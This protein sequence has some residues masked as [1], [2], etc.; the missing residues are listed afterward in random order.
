MASLRRLSLFLTGAYFLTSFLLA[1]QAL[2]AP[3]VLFQSITVPDSAATYPLSINK[4]LIITGYY[5][6]NSGK[7]HGFVRCLDGR[8]TTFDVPG[9]VL[10]KPVSINAAGEI[11][12]YYEIAEG[13]VPGTLG[14]IRERDGA[15]T[16]FGTTAYPSS[17]PAQPVAINNAGEVVGNFP[18]AGL[19]SEA[20]VR[21]STGIVQTFSIT[22]GAAYSTFLTAVNAH[23]AV[24]G[25]GGS[26][27]LASAHGLLWNGQPPAPSPVA[28]FTE[29][30][31]PGSTGTF[32]TGINIR[33]EIVGCYSIGT[34]YYDFV[35]ASDGTFTTITPPGTVP[36]CLATSDNTVPGLYHLLPA[37]VS[38]NNR[39][40]VIGYT[41]KAAV[42][43]GFV[44]FP[45]GTIVPFAIPG[46]SLTIP[47][48]STSLDGLDILTGYYTKGTK[49]EGFI[50]LP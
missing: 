45:G 26:D 25:Y 17:F 30:S 13:G 31:F 23:G 3:G 50:A 12:G 36:S 37:S 5:L 21:S 48:S 7:T 34:V 38:L 1:P 35:R 40:T 18:Q 20:F 43:S 4:D 47:A 42:T 44:R 16:T 41:T 14:F 49:T 15:I 27:D 22:I 8:I 39:G 33:G 46:S 9:S 6:D 19:G 10:T 32:P 29:I 28:G 24:V 11:T 2:A